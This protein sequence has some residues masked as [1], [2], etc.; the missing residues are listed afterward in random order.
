MR[1]KSPPLDDVDDD[2]M[3]YLMINLLEKGLKVLFVCFLKK[4]CGSNNQGIINQRILKSVI[5]LMNL[6]E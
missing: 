5:L 6:S 3:F 4:E 2:I 1:E